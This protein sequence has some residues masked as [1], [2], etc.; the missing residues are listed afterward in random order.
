MVYWF[1][2][3]QRYISVSVWVPGCPPVTDTGSV[4][5]D[6]PPNMMIMDTAICGSALLHVGDP[7]EQGYTY[8]WSPSSGLSGSNIPD[9]TITL[10]NNTNQPVTYH[11]SLHVTRGV[12]Y[13]T[14]PETF[15]VNPLPQ[16]TLSWDTLVAR[17][18]FEPGGTWCAG[19]DTTAITLAGGN[20]GGGIYSGTGVSNN[21]F[22]G[23]SALRSGSG[24]D[25]IY[26]TYTNTYGCAETA[27]KVVYLPICEG[28]QQVSDD[29]SIALY[30]NPVMEQLFIKTENMQ[31]VSV[32]IYDAD[33]RVVYS[34]PFK[35]EIDISELSTGVYFVEV[36]SEG[37]IARKRL[38]K[39]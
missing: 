6:A 38:I 8:Q 14:V 11:Y 21:I 1:F 17:H 36:L 22:Y 12:C 29:K 23:D 5:V 35:N 26:Y 9:P 32:N 28:V 37:G 15:T 19:T 33:G 31:P 18:L 27:F 34:M 39:L 7:P 16:V 3:G 24:I 25:T 2:A 30:P 20:P 10:T 13:A 4:W